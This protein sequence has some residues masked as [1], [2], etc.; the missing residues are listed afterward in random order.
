MHTFLFQ[1]LPYMAGALFVCGVTYRIAA[2][3]KT[4]QAYSTQ[5]LSNDRL[6]KWGS[7]FF[8]VGIILVFFGHIFGLLAPEWAYDWLITNEQKR[9]LAILMGSGAGLITFFG[10]CMLTLRRFANRA[11]VANSHFGD[12]LFVILI[13][14]QIVT[15]LMGTV[16]TVC[17]DLE[18]Y[19]NLDRWAQGLFTFLPDSADFIVDASLPHKIHILLGFL[20]VIIF[21]FTKL[22]HMTAL[23]VRYLIDYA[24]GLTRRK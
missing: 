8:H 13:F 24:Q 21:P 3:G 7:N 16:E 18:H 23:P 22:M 12:Y 6:L 5:F 4:V 2:Q 11:V 20:L 17:H 10:I 19:M 15:G 1:Y 14:L 9:Q